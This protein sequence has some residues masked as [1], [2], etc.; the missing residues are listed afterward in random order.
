LAVAVAVAVAA[1]MAVAVAV[2]VAGGGG[3]GGG[4]ALLTARCCTYGA[5]PHPCSNL[6]SRGLSHKAFESAHACQ[7]QLDLK[8]GRQWPRPGHQA[9]RINMFGIN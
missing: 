2:V 9:G 1:A 5:L 8:C 4:T 6:Q 3:G 7:D